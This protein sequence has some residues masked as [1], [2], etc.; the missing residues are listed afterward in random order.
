[1]KLITDTVFISAIVAWFLLIL[2]AFRAIIKR[3]RRSEINRLIESFKDL[4]EF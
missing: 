2:V 4:G 1:M 3:S